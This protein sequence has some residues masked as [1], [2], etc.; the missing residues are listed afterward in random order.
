MTLDDPIS[1]AFTEMSLSNPQSPH[2]PPPPPPPPSSQTNPLW[3][4]H[5]P[6]VP[7]NPDV[8][9]L[10]L[11]YDCAYRRTDGIKVRFGWSIT[12]CVLIS[13]IKNSQPS[14]ITATLSLTDEIIDPS[15]KAYVDAMKAIKNAAKECFD[16]EKNK[17]ST[18]IDSNFWIGG[19]SLV[20][21]KDEDVGESIKS[22][23][24]VRYE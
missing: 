14:I 6:T 7:S 8:Q 17:G 12:I 10:S 20:G 16:E 1:T 5:K 15:V 23:T 19:D 2:P 22:G 9:M 24:S 11:N 3:D 4:A 21:I 13:V 18:F